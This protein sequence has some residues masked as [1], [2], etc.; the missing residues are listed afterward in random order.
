MAAGLI[1]EIPEQPEN[2]TIYVS[3]KQSAE[4]TAK[5]QTLLVKTGTAGEE[6]IEQIEKNQKVLREAAPAPKRKFVKQSV[7]A[8]KTAPAPGWMN[9]GK[10][11]PETLRKHAERAKKAIDQ[12][13]MLKE[14]KPSAKG[15]CVTSPLA[16]ATYWESMTAKY[17]YYQKPLTGK[18]IG[19]LKKLGKDLGD[20]ATTVIDFALNNW[21]KFASKAAAEAGTGVWTYESTAQKFRG[22]MC[23]NFPVQQVYSAICRPRPSS[24]LRIVTVDYKGVEA[25][26][27]TS[28]RRSP[29]TG[30][31][32]PH[33]PK[34][35][36]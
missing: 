16:L 25:P 20:K 2:K 13:N 28:Q 19:R 34:S 30:T 35:I 27:R 21:W 1:P 17:N 22:R 26:C 7:E 18:E 11:L 5:P 31:P 23:R 24:N 36:R 32:Y 10:P 12:E 4:L 3:S 15:D 9:A 33:Q 8:V 29:R 6:N 14:K